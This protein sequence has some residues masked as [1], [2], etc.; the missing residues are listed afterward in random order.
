LC[1]DYFTPVQVKSLSAASASAR[2]KQS[3]PILRFDMIEGRDEKSIKK[4]LDAAHEAVLKAFGVPI[5]D[6]YQI[7]H[8]HPAHELIVEDTGLGIE[9]SRNVVVITIN[10]VQRTDAQKQALYKAMAEELKRQCDIDPRDVVVSIVPNSR[11]DW[12]FGL[13]EAQFL[14]G[15]L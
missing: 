8:Q 15:K 6:R 2:E 14:T 7:V 11:A 13:G 1:D 9:R 5:R 4:L 10:S 3:M 12:S